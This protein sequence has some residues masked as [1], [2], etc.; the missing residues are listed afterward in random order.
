MEPNWKLTVAVLGWGLAFTPPGTAQDNPYVS[1]RDVPIGEPTAAVIPVLD[2]QTVA[3]VIKGPEHDLNF[4]KL[5][6][7]I[8]KDEEALKRLGKALFWDMQVGSDGIQACA[9]CHFNAGVDGRS[10]NQISPGL[11]DTNFHG[12]FISGDNHFG[13]S[14]VP[15]TANDR[16]SPTPPGPSEPP[17]PNFN[18]PGFPQFKPNYQLTVGD[19]PLNGWLRP[20]E[21]TPRGPGVD[22]LEEFANV[23]RDTNDVISSQ[24]VRHTEFTSVTPGNPIDAGI[25]QPDIF[26]LLNPGEVEQF[27]V[28]RRVSP[29]NAP[30]VINAVYNFDNFWDGRASFI[31]NGVNPFGFRDRLNTLKVHDKSTGK[32][33]DVFVRITNSSL[34]SQAVGPATSN[35]EMSYENRLFPDIGRKML[36]I[37]PLARQL[38][39]PTDSIL[40]SLVKPR[41]D[42]NK[43]VAA[44]PGL[45]PENYAEMIKAAFRD[46]W[47][48]DTADV[49]SAKE[50]DKHEKQAASTNNPRTMNRGLGRGEVAKA[51][52]STNGEAAAKYYSQMEWNFSFFWG[53]AIQAYEQTLRSDDTPFDRFEEGHRDA[54]TPSERNGLS[55]FMDEDPNLG[56]HC[57]NCHAAP[58]MTNHSVVD[59]VQQD[60]NKPNFQGRPLEILESMVMGDGASASYDNGF[61]NIGVR[62]TTDDLG[63]A[64]TAPATT[65]DPVTHQILDAEHAFENDLDR[66]Q[67]GHARPFPLSYVALAELAAADKLPPDV[68]R[69]IQ[70]DP[71]TKKPAKVLDRQAI[72]GSFKAPNLRN[73]LY[74]GPYF[75]NGDSASLRHVVEFYTRGGNFPN[76]NFRDL[77]TDVFGIPGLRF[78]EFRPTAR[79]NIHDLVAFVA[80]GLTDERVAC[81]KAP[82]DHPQLFVPNGSLD[83]QPAADS[84]LEIPAVGETGR[85]TPISTFLDLDPQFPDAPVDKDWNKLSCD[86]GS[87]RH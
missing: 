55:I 4:K 27:D 29:R 18:V 50:A 13:N 65:F 79:K 44:G 42:G 84:M 5:G 23:S 6:D 15:F 28:V 24:G 70:L 73:V 36:K 63:R 57:N 37:K 78:P 49:V 64:L 60:M 66:D 74:T 69:F 62:R 25:P 33:N 54:L 3:D 35:I 40:H 26:N 85:P 1:L 72:H 45:I 77:D 41:S 39:H 68:L 12:T 8:V 2:T 31:F 87:G 14:T 30:P 9:T 59:I 22:V 16:L 32:L 58:V 43:A 48:D 34:A 19:F 52:Q 20:T 83:N 82:F 61:Y 56:A 11:N 81:E 80:L 51:G 10:K 21:L 71:I 17:D 7:E 53:L 38:V 86:G 67:D 76:T 47:W 75:H 46:Q